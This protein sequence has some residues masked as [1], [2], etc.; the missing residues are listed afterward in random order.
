MD[1]ID[2]MLAKALTP[3]GKTDIYVSKANKAAAKAEKAEA[4]AQAAIDVVTNAAETIALA[5][6]EAATLLETAQEALETAQ[7]AQINTLDTED[8]DNEIKKLDV[9][10]N[11]IDGQNSKLIQV[12][13]TYPDNTLNTENITRLYKATGANEDGAMTQKA[14]TDAL[15]NKVDNTTLNTYASKTYVDNAIA[16]GVGSGTGGISNLGQDVAGHIV[17]VGE[18]GHIT[19]GDTT[20][21]QIIEALIH[22]DIYQA[23]DSVGLDIDYENKTFMRTQ[24]A[25]SFDMGADFDAFSMYGGRMRCNVADNGTITAFYGEAN[26]KDD[27]SNGQVMFYQPKFY[28]QRVILKNESATKGRIIRHESIILS[29]TKQSGFKL[30][31]IFD[32]GNGEE[33]DYVLISAYEGSLISDR[34][35]SIAGEQPTTNISIIDAE[36]YARARGNGWHIMN[37]A[38][39]SAMQMLEIV[40][41]GSMNGQAAIEQ[42]VSNLTFTSGKNCSAITGSTAALGNAT[43]HAEITISNNNGTLIENTEV[44]KRAISY[45][46]MENPWGNVWQMIGGANIKGDGYSQGGA[47]YICNDF[48]YTPLTISNNYEYVGFNLPSQYGWISAMGYGNQK[49]DWVFLPLECSNSAN[50]LLPVGDNLWTV[51]NVSSNKIITVGGTY[52]FQESNGPFY[53]ACDQTAS[54]NSIHTYNARLMFIP[55]KNA[56]Y[57]NNIAKWTT[58]MGG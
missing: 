33:Y 12:V 39:V 44:G 45:R 43:G 35:A 1:I 54:N 58:I 28:Y 32:A 38:A 27:G 55:T 48:N 49:Y 4:D 20:E 47:L 9:S 3:Q 21:S 29:P 6:E 34:L 37:M 25:I 22:S 18:D 14:I 13:T 46:G 36:N 41:F 40:E 24:Q 57:N 26:Y 17:V 50:S 16:S 19:A 23:K 11:E 52:G 30:H 56:I 5:Q 53:Y 42:G 10:I 2:I 51:S 31:P 15:A 7:A 8:V